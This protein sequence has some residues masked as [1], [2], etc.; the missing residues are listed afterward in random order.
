[1]LTFVRAVGDWLRLLIVQVEAI[2]V[3][4][5]YA[6]RTPTPHLAINVI[7]TPH[8]DDTMLPWEDLLRNHIPDSG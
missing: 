6:Q 4:E 7:A 1:M 2:D 8:P 3:L 5:K